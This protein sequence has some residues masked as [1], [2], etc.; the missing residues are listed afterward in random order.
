MSHNWNQWRKAFLSSRLAEPVRAVYY[1]AYRALVIIWCG[2]TALSEKLSR[3]CSDRP[4]V[5]PPVLRFRVAG[6]P[7]RTDFLRVG[8]QSAHN[9]IHLLEERHPLSS[10]QTVLDF[11]CGCARTLVWLTQWFPEAQFFGTDTDRTAIAWCRTHLKSV[12]FFDNDPLPPLAFQ[13]QSLD[14]IYAISVFTHLHPPFQLRWLQEF[15]RILKTDGLLVL[16][17]HG[18]RVWQHLDDEHREH[19]QKFGV[20][21][22]QSQKLE[23]IFPAWYQTTFHTREYVLE[24]FGAY[25]KS[26]EYVSEGM[27]YQDVVLCRPAAERLRTSLRPEKV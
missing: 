25:F 24:T 15:Q 19:V 21:V 2:V 16:S 20:L 4:V 12:Q 10:C 9:L 13:P 3:E 7:S 18:K 17:L 1:R 23:G 8:E 27:G 14:L 11:G 22:T 26:I 6:T 5:P